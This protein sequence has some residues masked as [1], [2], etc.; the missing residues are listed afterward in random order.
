MSGSG[1]WSC[2]DASSATGGCARLGQSIESAIPVEWVIVSLAHSGERGNVW[3][4]AAEPDKVNVFHALKGED[5]FIRHAA[6]WG[7]WCAREVD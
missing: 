5:F 7:R 6:A 1:P 3:R 4:R 2:A